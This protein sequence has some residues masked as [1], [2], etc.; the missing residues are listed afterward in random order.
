MRRDLERAVALVRNGA[1][2]G[3]A[4]KKLKLTRNAVAGACT[5]A[6]VRKGRDVEGERAR[7]REAVRLYDKGKLRPSEIAERLG[8]SVNQISVAARRVGIE[9]KWRRVGDKSVMPMAIL[10]YK[11]GVSVNEI[12]RRVGWA[13]PGPLYHGLHA[14]GVPLRRVR[15]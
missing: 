5:R 8:C 13:N 2:Y 11:D 3:Q 6:G 12:A 9:P 4:A 10:L 15:A 1:S 7:I 14:H